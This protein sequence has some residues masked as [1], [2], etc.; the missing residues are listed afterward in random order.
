M[1]KDRSMRP[2]SRR[3]FANWLGFGDA[4]R[5]DVRTAN[6]NVTVKEF[7]AAFPIGSTQRVI[8]VDEQGKYAGLI[9]VPDLHSD[10]ERRIAELAAIRML[11]CS[12]I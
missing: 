8:I 9:I 5:S 11:S 3:A 7:R 1:N 6:A 10:P 2:S 4:A 12:Q